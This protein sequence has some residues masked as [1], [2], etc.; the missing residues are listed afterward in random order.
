MGYEDLCVVNS[1]IVS[2]L[3]NDN[4]SDDI[5]VVYG[6][7]QKNITDDDDYSWTGMIGTI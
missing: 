4:D 5:I 6:G 3:K 1:M 7:G 2:N